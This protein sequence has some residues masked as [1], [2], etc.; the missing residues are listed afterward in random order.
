MDRIPQFDELHQAE[1]QLQD[2]L[3]MRARESLESLQH[4]YN[5]QGE[6]PN[7]WLL[8]MIRRRAASSYISELRE[9]RNV[10]NDQKSVLEKIRDYYTDIFKYRPTEGEI[11]DFLNYKVLAGEAVPEMKTLTADQKNNLECPLTMDELSEALKNGKNTSSPGIDSF[12]Y[13]WLKVF[14][15]LLKGVLYSA[16]TTALEKGQDRT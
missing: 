9:G 14:Y 12:T 16:Y 8:K 15:R 13:G 2:H 3:E 10:F 1:L 4:K 7:S 5:L 11:S 6:K